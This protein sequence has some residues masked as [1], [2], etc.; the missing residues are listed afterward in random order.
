[1]PVEKLTPG[2]VKGHRG[3]QLPFIAINLSCFVISGVLFRDMISFF[4]STALKNIAGL[5]NDNRG[6]ENNLR[7]LRGASRR[8]KCRKSVGGEAKVRGKVVE[9]QRGEPPP[10]FHVTFIPQ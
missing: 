4:I 10:A 2:N 6:K 3:A 1:M 8:L 9:G 5:P 7:Y